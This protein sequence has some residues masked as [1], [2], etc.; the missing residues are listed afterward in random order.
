MIWSWEENYKKF[1]EEIWKGLWIENSEEN[2]NVKEMKY[3]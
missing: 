1:L 3:E 2:R